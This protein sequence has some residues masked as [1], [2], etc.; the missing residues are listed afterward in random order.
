MHPIRILALD[1][2]GTLIK[3]RD[4]TT[5]QQTY[6]DTTHFAEIVRLARSNGHTLIAQ[7]DSHSLG[8]ADFI[9]DNGVHW[10]DPTRSYFEDNRAFAA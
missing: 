1:L 4:Q 5:L 7:R 2:D 9:I 8:G 3:H 10:N 6:I